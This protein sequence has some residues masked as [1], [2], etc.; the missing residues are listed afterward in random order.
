MT[1]ARS[2][3]LV[4]MLAGA[5]GL[6]LYTTHRRYAARDADAAVVSLMT[7]RFDGTTRA[8]LSTWL[9][10][11]RAAEAD[12]RTSTEARLPGPFDDA[13]VIDL[14]INDATHRFSVGIRDRRPTA[15][16]ASARALVDQLLADVARATNRK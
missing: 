16:G 8:R 9:E 3:I 14:R 2:A 10:A 5:A 1:A 7:H 6:A 15:L 13:V 12:L 4:A 11:R